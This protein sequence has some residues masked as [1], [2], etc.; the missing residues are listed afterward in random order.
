MAQLPDSELNSTNK[1]IMDEIKVNTEC[2]QPTI[3]DNDV[4][5][6]DSLPNHADSHDY[7]NIHHTIIQNRDGA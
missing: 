4:C 6:N 1:S 3:D 5:D 2:N 7:D